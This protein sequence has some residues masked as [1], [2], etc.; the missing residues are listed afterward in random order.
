MISYTSK[1]AFALSLLVASHAALAYQF[2]VQNNTG[3][4]LSGASEH[5]CNYIMPGSFCYGDNFADDSLSDGAV[6][7]YNGQFGTCVF[8]TWHDPQ[9]NTA[10][11]LSG[12]AH[13][14]VSASG[15]IFNFK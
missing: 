8:T 7:I 12:N 15:T 5:T 6:H 4:T 13:C 2:V 3:A 10:H 11:S 14:S 9:K 1:I